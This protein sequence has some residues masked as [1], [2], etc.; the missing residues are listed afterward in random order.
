[1]IVLFN[2]GSQLLT[3]SLSYSV[4]DKGTYRA[5]RGQLKIYIF[6]YIGV[7]LGQH[8]YIFTLI[9]LKKQIAMLLDILHFKGCH[10]S[11]YL[12]SIHIDYSFKKSPCF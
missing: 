5:V 9:A 6:S 12:I 1:M 10:G 3:Q 11:T 8:I 2:N 4:S 7:T